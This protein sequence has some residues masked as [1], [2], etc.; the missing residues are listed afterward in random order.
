MEAFD[1][2]ED[3]LRSFM[4]LRDALLCKGEEVRIYIANK[5]FRNG[6]FPCHQCKNKYMLADFVLSTLIASMYKN[7]VLNV[8]EGSDKEIDM[9]PGLTEDQC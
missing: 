9:R 8:L 3:L 2:G 5:C 6:V 1:C 7:G 4:C